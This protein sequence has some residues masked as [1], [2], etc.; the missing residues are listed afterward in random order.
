MG[1][2]VSTLCALMDGNETVSGA[3][4]RLRPATKRKRRSN[5]VSRLGD[6]DDDDDDEG[7]TPEEKKKRF[8][9]LSSGANRLLNEGCLDVY[10]YDRD[11]LRQWYR[12]E[13]ARLSAEARGGGGGGGGGQSRQ[14]E[15]ESSATP[16]VG[17]AGSGAHVY[18][19]TVGDEATAYG[20]F[21]GPQMLRW[22]QGGYFTPER[23]VKIKQSKS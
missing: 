13:H 14:S 12:R 7:V 21:S 3:L 6:A 9:V 16:Q 1:R 19:Y 10:G 20:P 15:D 4:R 5:S 8:E 2:V 11:T 23:R 17:E 22:N 18:F